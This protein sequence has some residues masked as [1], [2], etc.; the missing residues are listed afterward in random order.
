M[1]VFSNIEP[2]RILYKGKQFFLIKDGF[3]VSP[4]HI[5]IISNKEKLDYFE[6][7]KKSKRQRFPV[8]LRN[9]DKV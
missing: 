3:P 8:F 5:L 2:N 9:K 4:G 7:D 1:S 6:L